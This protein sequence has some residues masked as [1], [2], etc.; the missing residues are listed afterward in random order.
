MNVR[1]ISDAQ[2]KTTDLHK[3]KGAKGNIARERSF[4]LHL[5]GRQRQN[6]DSKKYEWLE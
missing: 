4:V 5:V 3:A 6:P 2:Q 1:G